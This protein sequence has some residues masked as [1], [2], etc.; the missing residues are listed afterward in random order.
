MANVVNL[1][2]NIVNQNK[3]ASQIKKFIPPQKEEIEYFIK[4]QEVYWD[5]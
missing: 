2:N 1:A 4:A 3:I 5:E